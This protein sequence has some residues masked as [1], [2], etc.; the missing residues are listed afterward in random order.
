M[1]NDI[2]IPRQNGTQGLGEWGEDDNAFEEGAGKKERPVYLDG[3]RIVGP[4]YEPAL[5][6][7]FFRLNPEVKPVKRAE[8]VFDE[9]NL[10]GFRV[11]ENY[12]LPENMRGDKKWAHGALRFTPGWDSKAS[13]ASAMDSVYYDEATGE[14]HQGQLGTGITSRS[15]NY[16]SDDDA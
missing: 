16:G 9:N 4:T 3:I 5:V 15:V 1:S 11:E 8:V 7:D 13:T 12:G 14:Y 6:A 2:Y 10:L